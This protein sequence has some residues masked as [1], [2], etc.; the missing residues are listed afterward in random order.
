MKKILLGL[1]VC[2]SCHSSIKAQFSVAD[3]TLLNSIFVENL[4]IS[5][6]LYSNSWF[7]FPAPDSISQV[8]QQIDASYPFYDS[9][10]LGAYAG[11]QFAG[12]P[13][14]DSSVNARITSYNTQNNDTLF[15]SLNPF[16]KLP[17]Q[18]GGIQGLASALFDSSSS[19]VNTGDAFVI[20]TGSGDNQLTRMS[21]SANDYH[22]VNCEIRYHLKPKGDVFIVG[23]ANE[24]NRALHF[25][26]KKLGRYYPSMPTF[27]QTYLNNSHHS[28]GVNRLIE[29]IAWVKY[30]KTKYNRVYVLGLSSG[31]TEALWVSLLSK[32]KGTLVASG[33]SVLFDTDSLF[34]TVNGYFYGNYMNYFVKDT[35]KKYINAGSTYYY[36]THALGDIPIFQQDSAG[37]FTRSFYTGNNKTHFV[38]NY[39]N[40]SFPPCG[41]IDT[42]LNNVTLS[43]NHFS[44]NALHVICSGLAESSLHIDFGEANKKEVL[45]YDMSGRCMD[46][47]IVTGFNTDINSS[48]WPVGVYVLEVVSRTGHYHQKV[49]KY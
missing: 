21:V 8:Y 3:S 19:S 10:L 47:R 30:L 7:H 4:Y 48:S 29:T 39:Y 24:D 18:L 25:N 16:V 12:A 45:L 11:I 33:Y 36:F 14:Y 32:P 31:G 28:M 34:Q 22:N 43:V 17:F 27:L 35:V 44:N 37:N 20:L 42:F 41:L 5:Q 13:E 6:P 9:M 2:L 38:S 40:H 49:V 15:G 26:K 23:E 46:K 1:I